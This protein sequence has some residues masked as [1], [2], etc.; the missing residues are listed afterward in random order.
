MEP[1]AAQ[2]A[3]VPMANA[4]GTTARR[5]CGLHAERVCKAEVVEKSEMRVVNL[6]FQKEVMSDETGCVIKS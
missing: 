4:T 3:E 2:R 1:S 5:A 6:E